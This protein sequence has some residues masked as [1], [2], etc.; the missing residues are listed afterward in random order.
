MTAQKGNLAIILAFGVLL[1][2]LGGSV[3]YNL[4]L[5]QKNS[6]LERK[7]LNSTVTPSLQTQPT[8][9]INSGSDTIMKFTPPESGAK[10][11]TSTKGFS[12]DLPA[13]LP[14]VNENILPITDLYPKPPTNV[15]IQGA[16]MSMNITVADAPSKLSINNAL[17]EGPKL[18]YEYKLINNKNN[19]FRIIKVAGI[20]AIRADGV[21]GPYDMSATDVIF[22]KDGLIYEISFYPVTEVN[23]KLF[24]GVLNSFKFN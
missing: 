9:T 5:S 19:N 20:D 10:T 18:N 3:F 12:V 16:S 21:K 6:E 23:T 11:Y 4:Q 13:E 15:D 14:V 1:I 7:Q 2:V 22:F 24:E 17:G 8:D